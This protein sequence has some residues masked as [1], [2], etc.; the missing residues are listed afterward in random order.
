LFYEVD[1]EGDVQRDDAGRLQD[2][3]PCFYWVL[4]FEKKLFRDLLLVMHVSVT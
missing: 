3:E 2:D 4:F 1:G